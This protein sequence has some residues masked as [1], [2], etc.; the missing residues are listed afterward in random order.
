MLK[1]Q[2]ILVMLARL[3]NG[4]SGTRVASTSCAQISLAKS[5]LSVTQ[6]DGGRQDSEVW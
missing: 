2:V 6:R 3:P 1:D 4:P 5:K